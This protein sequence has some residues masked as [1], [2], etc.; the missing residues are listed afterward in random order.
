MEK[1][2]IKIHLSRPKQAF[3]L[4]LVLCSIILFFLLVLEEVNIIVSVL[5]VIFLFLFFL[6]I[7]L[8]TKKIKLRIFKVYTKYESDFEKS[9]EEF[10]S[11]KEPQIRSNAL[12]YSYRK[13]L[14]RKCEN[15]GFILS[16]FAKKC[17]NCGNSQQ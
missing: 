9:K 10:K 16:Q 8:K 13:P 11:E 5:I 4:L 15:C 12:K 1:N 6:G 2:A 14:V 3:I 17:P 7:I